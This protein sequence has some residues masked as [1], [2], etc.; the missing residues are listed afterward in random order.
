[1]SFYVK[2][3]ILLLNYTGL[4][5]CLLCNIAVP[6]RVIAEVLRDMYVLIPTDV[7]EEPEM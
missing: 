6:I 2:I 3:P 1:M 7:W 5:I 4:H